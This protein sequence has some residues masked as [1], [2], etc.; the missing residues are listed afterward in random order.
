ME[1]NK[2]KDYLARYLEGETSLKEEEILRDYFVNTPNIPND[3]KVYRSFFTYFE[4][5]KKEQ[6]PAIKKVNYRKILQPFVAVAAVLAI[7]FTLQTN[8]VFTIENNDEAELEMAF[9][10]FQ[11]QMKQMSNHLN[12]GTQNIAY[13]DYWNTTTLKLTNKKR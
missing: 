8:G 9:K 13:L 3:L 11:T 1:L 7:V 6:F 2:I 10:E 4:S 12:R 5:A